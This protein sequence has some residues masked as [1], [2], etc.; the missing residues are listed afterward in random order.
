MS[1]R[2]PISTFE[3]RM[4]ILMR[5]SFF[6]TPENKRNFLSISERKPRLRQFLRKCSRMQFL[7]LFLD[8][9][10]KRLFIS[11]TKDLNGIS[12]SVEI[13]LKIKLRMFFDKSLFSIRDWKW[14]L[15]VGQKNEA[16]SHKNFQEREFWSCLARRWSFDVMWRL[17]I[18]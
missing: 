2:K 4:I 5:I 3:T 1:V 8:W 12:F 7:G 11:T 17:R 18:F 15:K 14:F 13:W 9:Y 6:Q 16:N 10:W